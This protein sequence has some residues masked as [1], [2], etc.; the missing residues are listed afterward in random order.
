MSAP[1]TFSVLLPLFQDRVYAA[2]GAGGMRLASLDYRVEAANPRPDRAIWATGPWQDA[3][4]YNNL[5][6][7]AGFDR[8]GKGAPTRLRFD[9]DGLRAEGDPSGPRVSHR[10]EPGE[11]LALVYVTDQGRGDG[12]GLQ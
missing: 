3:L 7:L 9:L 11:D 12:S 8:T 2:D 4:V 6:V 10:A 5:G 1:S